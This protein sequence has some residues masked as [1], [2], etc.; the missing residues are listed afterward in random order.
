MSDAGNSVRFD[1]VSPPRGSQQQHA[2]GGDRVAASEILKQLGS[3]RQKIGEYTQKTSALE[4]TVRKKKDGVI[5]SKIKDQIEKTVENITE[6]Q[7]LVPRVQSENNRQKL[8]WI[9]EQMKKQ[10]EAM[11]RVWKRLRARKTTQKLEEFRQERD[12]TKHTKERGER[13]YQ[14]AM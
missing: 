13:I 7:D 12:K 6:E 9:T 5:E 8:K 10:L 3:I 2:N 4:E 1:A 11:E 14:G